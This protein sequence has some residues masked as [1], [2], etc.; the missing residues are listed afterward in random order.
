MEI[1]LPQSTLTTASI[2][3]SA[4]H[5]QGPVFN[6]LSKVLMQNYSLNNISASAL[7]WGFLPILFLGSIQPWAGGDPSSTEGFGCVWWKSKISS[8][9]IH[10]AFG[11]L[12]QDK[13]SQR[14][15]TE[16]KQTLNGRVFPSNDGRKIPG[17]AAEAEPWLQSLQQIPAFQAA[18]T[19]MGTPA[20]QEC[21]NPSPSV[22]PD[23]EK[24]QTGLNNFPNS[25]H[26]DFTTPTSRSNSM[27]TAPTSHFLPIFQNFYPREVLNPEYP[28][29]ENKKY[30]HFSRDNSSSDQ[31]HP[32]LRNISPDFDTIFQEKVKDQAPLPDF[33][34]HIH[35][36]NR[37]Q[38]SLWW[39]DKW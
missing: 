26:T 14:N 31:A 5:L 8:T 27:L 20:L 29:T 19:A 33:K 35:E 12:F 11:R 3:T 6:P 39:G 10:P 28:S 13:F 24:S 4:F 9:E 23:P 22:G 36:D 18:P 1:K 7:D 15:K 34:N 2:F 16:S 37:Y 25:V 21:L 32:E 30:Q 17:G 38:N